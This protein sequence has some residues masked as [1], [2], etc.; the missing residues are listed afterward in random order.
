MNARTE[1]AAELVDLVRT[2]VAEHL[3]PDTYDEH[4][5][6]LMCLDAV[7]FAR[8]YSSH[9]VGLRARAAASLLLHLACP[10]MGPTLRHELSVACEL[11]AIGAALQALR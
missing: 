3:G 2:I 6:A 5:V 1:H 7:A 9:H 4:L 11:V 8:A 10:T